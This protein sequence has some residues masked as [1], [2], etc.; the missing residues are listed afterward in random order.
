MQPEIHFKEYECPLLIQL[1][2]SLS[3]DANKQNQIAC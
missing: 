3:H 1:E 2:R